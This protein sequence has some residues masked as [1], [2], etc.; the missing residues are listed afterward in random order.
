M[1]IFSLITP[2]FQR[3]ALLAEMVRS[4]Q[5]Q[6]L[7]DWELLIVDDQSAAADWDVIQ[8]HGADPRVRLIRRYTGLKGPNTCRNLG[9]ELSRGEFVIFLD[10]DD[11]LAP[12]CLQ[13][14]FETTRNASDCNFWVFQTLI[15]ERI[16]GDRNQLWNSL[17]GQD[18]TVRF[19]SSSPPWCMTSPLWRREAI[20]SIGGL[21]PVLRYGTDSELHTRALLKGLRYRKYPDLPADV[22]VRRDDAP[23]FNRTLTQDLFDAQLARITAGRRLLTSQPA[24]RDLCPLWEKQYFACLEFFIF[25]APEPRNWTKRLLEDWQQLPGARRGALML[26]AAYALCGRWCR[27]RAY[28]LLRV[29]RRL[30]LLG[31]G[32]RLLQEETGFHSANLDDAKFRALVDRI[33]AAFAD[34]AG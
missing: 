7:N 32:R 13:Q 22:F 20:L 26:L 28:L 23:R 3:P 19:L 5:L 11:L 2:H 25:N 30:V 17:E 4:V 34:A 6:T 9:L 33:T 15:F 16:P 18:D 12:W 10:S 31:P 21:D 27:K 24:A 29:V 1:P 8:Q 14:R